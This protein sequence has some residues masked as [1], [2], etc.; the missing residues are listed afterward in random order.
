MT[1]S[2]QEETLAQQ[3]DIVKTETKGSHVQNFGD[4]SYLNETISDFEGYENEISESFLE[5]I[6]KYLK[7]KMCELRKILNYPCSELTE[8]RENKRSYEEYLASAKNSTINSRKVKVE[9]FLR[10]YKTTNDYK[11]KEMLNKELLH[12]ENTD[13]IFDD[14]DTKFTVDRDE[15]IPEIKFDCLRD[16]VDSY[17]KCNVFGEYDL[18]FIRNIALACK[19]NKMEDVVQYFRNLC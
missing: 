10:K 8:T 3:F 4:L 9:Y 12:M 1:E 6:M 18:I 15:S 11:Y 5:K 13:R 16:S 17:K 19:N 2:N 14:F 7:I